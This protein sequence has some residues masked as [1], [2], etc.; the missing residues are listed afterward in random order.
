MRFLLFL[1]LSCGHGFR[2]SFRVLQAHVDFL[3][4]CQRVCNLIPNSRNLC[5]LVQNNETQ[6]SPDAASLVCVCVC[7]WL[8][9]RVELWGNP[10]PYCL[11]MM[12]YGFFEEYIFIDRILNIVNSV[13]VLH[14]LSLVGILELRWMGEFSSD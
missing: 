13:K 12:E 8:S 3:S 10:H 6:V 14:Q 4:P 11:Y 9:L 2:K 5:V 1:E 7:K